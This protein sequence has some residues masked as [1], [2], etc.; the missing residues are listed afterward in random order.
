MTSSS[1]LRVLYGKVDVFTGIVF[2]LRCIHFPEKPEY[3]KKHV[4]DEIDV[5]W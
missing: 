1:F 3:S 2:Y 4:L 5:Y